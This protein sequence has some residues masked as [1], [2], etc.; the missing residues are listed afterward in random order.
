MYSQSKWGSLC[1]SEIPVLPGNQFMCKVISQTLTPQCM[2]KG[3]GIQS[4]DYLKKPSNASFPFLRGE[5]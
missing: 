1:G 4:A 2:G 5:I 3:Q